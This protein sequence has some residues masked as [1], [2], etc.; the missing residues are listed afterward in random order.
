M[1]ARSLRINLLKMKMIF[2]KYMK[3]N[4]TDCALKIFDTDIDIQFPQYILNAISWEY[5]QE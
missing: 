3:E 2:S 5:V 4:K 1:N